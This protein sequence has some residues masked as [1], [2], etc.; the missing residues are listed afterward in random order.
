MILANILENLND[1][2]K[3]AVETIEGPLLILAGAGTG[4][5]KVL[6]TRVVNIINKQAAYPSEILCVTFTNKAAFEMKDRIHKMLSDIP[7]HSMWIGTFHSIGLRILRR[8]FAEAGLKPNFII[9]DPDD[10]E[11]IIKQILIDH[12][13]DVKKHS[14]KYIANTI[15]TLKD[16]NITVSNFPVSLDDIYGTM[17]L[18][19]IYNIY[20]NR[21]KAVNSVDFGD[22]LQLCVNLF[23]Q[24]PDIV[25]FWQSKFKFVLV[26][27]YQD[28]NLLQY[29]FIKILAAKYHNL[30]CV[31]D[32]D[33]SIYSWRGAEVENILRFE[34]DF[35]GAKVLRLEQNYRSINPILKAASS[36]ISA[37][38]K[39]WKKTLWTDKE[40]KNTVKLFEANSSKDEAQF[41]CD[42]ILEFKKEGA[43]Y[44]DNAILVRAAYQTRELEERLQFNG[45][46]YQLIG[47]LSFYDRAEVKDT[48]AHLR[49]LNQKY[50]DM[51]F[52]RIINNPKRGLGESALNKI[53]EI[54]NTNNTSLYLASE[55]ILGQGILSAKQDH[56]LNEF[57][58]AFTKVEQNQG[59]KLRE[60]TENILKNTGYLNMYE[61]EGTTEAKDRI[62]NIKELYRALDSYSSLEEFLESV[63]LRVDTEDE[64]GNDNKVCI[65]T[66]HRAKGLEFNC[67]FL[68]GWEEGILPNQ[69]ALDEGGEK[70]L[71]EERRLAYVGITRAKKKLF[72]S[73]CKSRNMYGSWQECVGSRFILDMGNDIERINTS[74]YVT[75]DKT[76]HNFV[77]N[78]DFT[79]FSSNNMNANFRQGQQVQHNSLGKG[80]IVSLSGPI[81]T[82][83][84]EVHGTKKI[85]VSFLK[86]VK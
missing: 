31:G 34:K 66:L 76:K 48:I 55:F 77:N 5:T 60:I 79:S 37:N 72:V 75:K 15:S 56:A 1:V 65:M 61:I 51:A 74:V 59:L 78:I 2:Q 16:K 35:K 30:C 58:S 33:Q 42:K 9:L 38:T 81:A 19:Q 4:K 63:S 12:N 43:P 46:D 71:E 54:A 67:V 18:S 40:D 39:R 36:L 21:L 13:V 82:V 23:I 49:L 85:M 45:I 47:G 25:D 27:E 83:N 8:H 26:D 41:I 6:T 7:I 70:S 84:F 3:E 24:F 20:N 14:P 64:E 44:K 80:V 22:L 28:T 10:C 52:L 62:E 69:R 32:D 86:E 17:S 57:V 11:R 50:D 68:P 29:T 53:R 73:Y